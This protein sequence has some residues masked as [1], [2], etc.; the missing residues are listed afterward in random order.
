VIVYIFN[1][2]ITNSLGNPKISNWLYFIPITV[3][4]TG[5][6]QSLNYWSNR[7]NSTKDLQLVE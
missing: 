4:L 2:Q 3:L 7:K 6:Y 5:I 1:A